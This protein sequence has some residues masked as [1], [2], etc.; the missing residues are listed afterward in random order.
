ML[1]CCTPLGFQK[2][3]I[4]L[5]NFSAWPSPNCSTLLGKCSNSKSCIRNVSKLHLPLDWWR[6]VA[7]EREKRFRMERTLWQHLYL[8]G[9][10]QTGLHRFRRRRE[11]I[12]R[13]GCRRSPRCSRRRPPSR[14]ASGPT[15]PGR[16]SRGSRRR[17][18]WRRS[19]PSWRGR[20]RWSWSCCQGQ[21]CNIIDQ[22][23]LWQVV[24]GW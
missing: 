4:K 5:Q 11:G 16:R 6:L 13:A 24:G 21:G 22:I 12:R 8:W 18:P 17:W 15:P 7:G 23:R 9:S 20:S 14:T 1:P 10:E 3:Q 2:F 19:P